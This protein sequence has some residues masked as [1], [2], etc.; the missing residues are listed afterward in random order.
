M[1]FC[2]FIDAL[3]VRPLMEN[4]I[5][6]FLE[7]FPYVVNF[8]FTTNITFLPEEDYDRNAASDSPNHKHYNKTFL[9]NVKSY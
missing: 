4:S 3:R 9:M 6:F 8:F 5:N 1:F 7:T 2:V